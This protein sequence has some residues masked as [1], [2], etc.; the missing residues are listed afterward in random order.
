MSDA[1]STDASSPRPNPVDPHPAD[2]RSVDPRSVDSGSVDSTSV[3][4]DSVD[5][6]SVDRD[7]VDPDSGDGS[8]DRGPAGPGLVDPDRDPV[9][10]DSLDSTSVDSDS[11]DGNSA[12]ADSADAV[13]VTPLVR[14]AAEGRLPEWAEAGEKRRAHMGRVA[15]LMREWAVALGLPADDVTRWTAAGW[16]HDALRDADPEALRPRVPERFRELNGK[17]LHGPAAAERIAGLADGELVEAVR[18]H[19]LGSPRFGTLGRALY[20]ADFLEPGRTFEREWTERLRGRMPREMDGVLREV[21]EARI[22]HVTKQGVT[23]HPETRAFYESVAK[24][25]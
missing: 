12:D 5:R 24:D 25:G 16:L 19:T 6:D 8:L 20:L 11:V 22:G 21:V 1:A 18:C 3:D 2:P 7:S 23:V 13:R 9:D 10:S 17:V 15:A 4:R 14:E